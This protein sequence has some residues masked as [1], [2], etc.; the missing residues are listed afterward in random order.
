M[1]TERMHFQMPAAGL[2]VPVNMPDD[3]DPATVSSVVECT[4]PCLSSAR[5]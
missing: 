5:S 3:I 4:S 1:T 2:R